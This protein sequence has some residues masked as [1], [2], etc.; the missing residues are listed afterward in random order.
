ML[1]AF[2]LTIYNKTIGSKKDPL[3][4]VKFSWRRTSR[5]FFFWSKIKALNGNI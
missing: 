3:V 1:E 2:K 4:T 5:L